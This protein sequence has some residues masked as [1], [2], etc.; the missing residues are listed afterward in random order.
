MEQQDEQID[1]NLNADAYRNL[2]AA[3]HPTV[4]DKQLEVILVYKG[5]F[6][7]MS[8]QPAFINN[9]IL[10]SFYKYDVIIF[11]NLYSI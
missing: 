3:D 8:D 6:Q 7:V 11:S 10:T 5:K 4:Q 2:S 9:I 1:P